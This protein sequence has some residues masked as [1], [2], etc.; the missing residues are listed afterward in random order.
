MYIS[1]Q[2][3]H[4]WLSGAYQP[5]MDSVASELSFCVFESEHWEPGTEPRVGLVLGRGFWSNV[6]LPSGLATDD[7]LSS[8]RYGDPGRSPGRVTTA[9]SRAWTSSWV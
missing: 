7:G 5:R 4:A 1:I 9:S 3:S 6:L 8:V 2:T